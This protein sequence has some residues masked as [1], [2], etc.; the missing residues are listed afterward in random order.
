MRYEIRLIGSEQSDGTQALHVAM[1]GTNDETQAKLYAEEHAW[2]GDSGA[3]IVDT[4]N[5]TVDTGNAV[6]PLSRFTL[7]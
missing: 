7:R 3:A 5:E 6:L 1:Y 2:D 4:V